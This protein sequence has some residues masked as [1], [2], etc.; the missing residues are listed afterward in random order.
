MNSEKFI[1]IDCRKKGSNKK[2]SNKFKKQ[3]KDFDS[4]SSNEVKALGLSKENQLKC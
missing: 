2:Q 1:L 4:K 3:E